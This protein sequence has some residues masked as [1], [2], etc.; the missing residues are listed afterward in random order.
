MPRPSDRTRIMLWG[1]AYT[2]CGGM[3]FVYS[4]PSSTNPWTYY[5]GLAFHAFLLWNGLCLLCSPRHAVFNP[6]LRR[7]NNGT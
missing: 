7:K 1:L 3:W 5:G 4:A 2:F 6:A